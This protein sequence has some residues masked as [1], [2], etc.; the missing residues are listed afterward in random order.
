MRYLVSL[1]IGGIAGYLIVEV[2]PWLGIALFV[3]YFI[4]MANG[5]ALESGFYD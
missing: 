5:K 1:I 2:A 4:G 3:V